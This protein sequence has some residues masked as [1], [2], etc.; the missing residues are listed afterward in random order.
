MNELIALGA[1]SIL[2]VFGGAISRMVKVWSAKQVIS[3]LDSIGKKT[4][5]DSLD[6][7]IDNM[8]QSKIGK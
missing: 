1:G 3:Q 4:M 7:Y 8:L 6:E 5:D 2:L